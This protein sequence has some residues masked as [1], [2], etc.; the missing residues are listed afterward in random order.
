MTSDHSKL[1]SASLCLARFLP[2]VLFSAVFLFALPAYAAD[3]W[4]MAFHDSRHTGQ[5]S[6]VVTA[7]MTLA[8]QWT[9][10]NSYD[11]SSQFHPS[12]RYFLP[13]FYQGRICFQ[14]GQNAN[15]VSC[16]NPVNGALLWQQ[17]NPGY[18][19][20]G[21]A[22]YQFDNY[23]AAVNGRIINASTDLSASMDA[24]TG[25]DARYSYNTNGSSPFGGVASWGNMA[26]YQ[27]VR[28]DD[29]TEA[30]YIA[31]DPVSLG[32][33]GYYSTPDNVNSSVDYAMR[34]PAVDAGIAYYSL[35][36]QLYA[37]DARTN[38]YMWQWGKSNNGSSPAVANGIVYFYASSQGKLLALDTNHI[39]YSPSTGLQIPTLWSA[40]ILGAYSP[41]V[42]D[43]VVYTGSADGKFYALDAKTGAT[44]WS[45]NAGIFSFTCFQIPA[46]SGNTVFVPTNQGL[47]LALNKNTGAELWRYTGTSPFGPV[48]VANGML[49]VSDR[50]MRVYGFTASSAAIGPAVT[51]GSVSRVSNAQQ[52]VVNLTGSGFFGGGA[53]SQVQRIQL[54]DPSGTQLLGYTVASDQSI[55]GV[56]IPPGIAPGIYHIRVQTSV[57]MSVNEPPIEVVAAGSL[58]PAT[59][60][61]T[62]GN[63]YGTAVQTQRHLA[64]TSTGNLI[65]VYAGYADP[66]YTQDPVYNISHDGGMTW[67]VQGGLHAAPW[68]NFVSA[69]APTSSIWID[70]QDHLNN[71]Y[72]R[73]TSD[74]ASLEK[75]AINNVDVLTA[76]AGFPAS[77]AS[78]QST[79]SGTGVS[80]SNGRRWVL[81]V[82][83]GQVI[84]RYSDDG[85]ITWNQMPAVN[86]ASSNL[87][88]LIS[89]N[90]QPVILYNDG[91]SL[92]W[93]QWNGTQWKPAQILP[94]PINGV[95]TFS[96]VTTTDGRIHV[97]YTGATGGV[98]Y[99]AYSGSAWSAPQTLNAAGSTPSITT[100]GTN[101]WCFYANSSGD[102]V[103]QRTSGGGWNPAVAVTSD[104]NYNT[105]PS[106]LAFSPDAKIPVIWT[107]GPSTGYTVKSAVI[108]ASAGAPAAPVA[109][110]VSA[111]VKVTGSVYVLNRLS[112]LY[113]STMTV[114]N[115]SSSPIN[116][117]I[118]TVLVNLSAGITLVN[119]AGT[120]NGSP[121]VVVTNGTLNP[122]ASLNVALQF[123]NP[124]SVYLTFKPVTYSGSF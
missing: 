114:T 53:S 40:S 52:V 106:T 36:G 15:R 13:I 85:G 81:F 104:G 71:S 10:T 50:M 57:A 94:G 6:E 26:Y 75:F 92:A 11:T 122:G 119:G 19:N 113:T 86:Q 48:V 12:Q 84:P 38:R 42:S 54:D 120:R 5:T 100:D 121:Y 4:V 118:Q 37:K 30:F 97:V 62:N 87:A 7:P 69:N 65:A 45:Y 91:N 73:W 20:N 8:W 82:V 110:D 95:Q 9:N 72:M 17:S 60:G 74:G 35:M 90:D 112:R 21:Y 80:Q 67:S 64:R 83:G 111:Q 55:T 98:F 77:V 2:A 105:L 89:S 46:I 14:G 32:L 29:G 79:V 24:A 103:F 76:D 18:A 108:P 27:F 115:I 88:S 68:A 61:A 109:S 99:V 124:G 63:L 43:G 33:T 3:D 96:A 22:L 41:I 23:P 93:S 78:G 16:L 51:A 34:V 66:G 44:K 25:G 70:A 58:F 28:T 59:L 101:L 31:Q 117:P 107:S 1:S 116:G 39:T 102:L 49:F 47:L 123:T 56:I